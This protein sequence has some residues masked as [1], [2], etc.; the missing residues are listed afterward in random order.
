[1][2][3]NKITQK[4]PGLKKAV[5]VSFSSASSARAL[6]KLHLLNYLLR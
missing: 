4:L 2:S 6:S 5:A 3:G 1:M